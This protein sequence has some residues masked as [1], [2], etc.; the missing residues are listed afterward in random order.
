MTDLEGTDGLAS[1]A[2]PLTN[3]CQPAGTSLGRIDERPVDMV[4][5]SI[6]SD[7]LLASREAIR[8]G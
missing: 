8:G 7:W 3:F 5:A 6:S 4:K 1:G 2:W